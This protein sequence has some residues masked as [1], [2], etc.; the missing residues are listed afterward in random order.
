MLTWKFTAAA[1]TPI[2]LGPVFVPWAMKP[3]QLEQFSTNNCRPRVVSRW[4]AAGEDA[5]AGL[6]WALNAA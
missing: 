1:P 4:E 3:W 2:R 5:E 6:P